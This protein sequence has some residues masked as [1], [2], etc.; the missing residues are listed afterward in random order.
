MPRKRGSTEPAYLPLI[1]ITA[2]DIAGATEASLAPKKQFTVTVEAALTAAQGR[3]LARHAAFLGVSQAELVR[4]AL[5]Q[6]LGDWL[7][8][9]MDGDEK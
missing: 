2:G 9:E 1:M 3:A 6:A 4:A 5:D 7:K 8:E